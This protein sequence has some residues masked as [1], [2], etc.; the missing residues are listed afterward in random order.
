MEKKYYEKRV[1]RSRSRDRS[2]DRERRLH[3]DDRRREYRRYEDR[4]RPDDRNRS[5]HRP[6]SENKPAHLR[7]ETSNVLVFKGSS[8]ATIKKFE[9]TA[10]LQKTEAPSN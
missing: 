3:R 6:R 2:R 8:N 7:Q 4:H 9:P 5:D 1:Q 10:R